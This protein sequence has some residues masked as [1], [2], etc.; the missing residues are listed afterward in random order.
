[1]GGGASGSGSSASGLDSVLDD[2]EVVEAGRVKIA[3]VLDVGARMG[4]ELRSR[5]SIDAG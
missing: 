5:G 1:M 3:V 2:E 4:V